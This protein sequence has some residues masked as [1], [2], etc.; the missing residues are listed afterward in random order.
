MNR[1]GCESPT[2][3]LFVYFWTRE[4][5]QQNLDFIYL[6]IYLFWLFFKNS[7]DLAVLPF[8]QGSSWLELGIVSFKW[9]SMV[10]FVPTTPCFLP[11]TETQC[12]LPCITLLILFFSSGTEIVFCTNVYQNW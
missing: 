4:T 1:R 3:Y 7:K 2:A 8:L 12:Q 6:F 11:F 9:T 5:K 10:Q